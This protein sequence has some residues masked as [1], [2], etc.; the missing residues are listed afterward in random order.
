[1]RKLSYKHTIAA[2]LLSGVVQAVIVNFAPLLFVTFQSEYGLSALQVTALIT[3]NFSLQLLT[4]IVASKFAPKIGV[5][6]CLV[7]ANFLCAAGLLLMPLLA[8]WLPAFLGLA[9]AVAV[10]AVGGGLIEV[11]T[12]PTV[13]A[14]PTQN[15]TGIM[16]VLH[17]FYCWGVAFTVLVSTLFFFLVGV[18]NWKILSCLWACLPAATALYF[19]FVPVYTMD[20]EESEK[21]GGV[22][23]FKKGTFLIL[24][25]MMICAGAA[26]QAVAQWVS[27]LT[28][29]G[30][31]VDKTAGDLI[32]VCGF[33]I[34]MGIARAL[35]GKCSEKITAT[36]ALAFCGGLAVIGYLMIGFSPVPVVGLLGCVVCG[37]AVGIL[38]PCTLSLAAKKIPAGG[39]ALFAFLAL[40]GDIGCTTGPTLV[41]AVSGGLSGLQTGVAVAIVFPVLLAVCA[42]ILKKKN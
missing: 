39:T 28:E 41:G 8:S 2:C 10:Y 37:L 26:E 14:C 4:D 7:A 21:Q 17:S 19:C 22:S 16:S 1:M 32:G 9:I 13:E 3:V 25:A 40:A 6:K 30:L 29:T 38:W 12:S 34:T 36:T 31:Q 24:F 15:K 5:K 18:E 23:L 11:L 42:L 20:T 35:Y 27:A 33:A